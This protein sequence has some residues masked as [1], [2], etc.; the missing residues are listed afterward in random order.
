MRS[1]HPSKR[2]LGITVIPYYILYEGVER[3]L[4][5]LVDRAEATAVACSP[6][7]GVP[8]EE[9]RGRFQPPD[10][11]GSSPRIFDRPLWGK[12]AL[13]IR[14][15]PSFYPC[16]DYYSETP[17]NPPQ[18]NDLTEKYG[19]VVKDFIDAACD[20]G[21]K[22]Y[23]Q[24]GASSPPNLRNE[25]V[26]L[27]PNGCLPKKRMANIGSLA[28]EAIRSYNRAYIHDL[29]ENY[30]RIAGIRLDW[31]E[32][33]CYM[34]DEAF[35]DFSSHVQKWAEMKEFD[36]HNI[37]QKV[38]SLY[39]RLHGGLTKRDLIEIASPDRGKN[40]MLRLLRRYP[41][42]LEWLRLK[43]ALS[44][45]LLRDWR[46]ALI[47]YGG[48]DK[49]LSANAFSPPFSILTGF[50]FY[51]AAD[52]CSA[53]SPKLYT[54]HWSVMVE[55]WGNEL[56]AANPGLDESVLVKALAH[57][58]DLG[59]EITAEKISDYGYPKPDEPHPIPN[60]AQVRKIEQVIAETAGR[61]QVTPIVH[62]YGPFADFCRRLEV[63][64]E[65]SADGVWVNRY[66][67]LSDEKLDAIGEIWR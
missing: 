18:P 58:F 64:V 54:M 17:Y 25:D 60:E 48:D 10:D 15:A 33:P 46:D 41:E 19:H 59:D 24:I 65:S 20:Y 9:G 31:P 56:L 1:D 44:L 38:E 27:L 39:N 26:P 55:F 12:K 22:V 14:G 28:S 43:S 63:V 51:N 50:D 34:I 47:N 6:F 40:L 23:L 21:L 16:K 45:D 53:V 66:G 2:F 57:L 36:F 4:K 5:N 67:Y 3:V 35:Q 42:I 7:I 61:A 62:G 37:L 8:A 29:L 32:Y 52:Y 49:E 30:P 11:A 13:W